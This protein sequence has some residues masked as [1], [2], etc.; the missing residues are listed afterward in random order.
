MPTVLHIDGFSTEPIDHFEVD[1][2]ETLGT[3][4]HRMG[5]SYRIEWVPDKPKI[6]RKLGPKAAEFIR[7]YEREEPDSVLAVYWRYHSLEA[8]EFDTVEEA[9]RFLENGAEYGSLAG[10]AVVD[11]DGKVTVLP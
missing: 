11:G 1:L 6:E 7:D 10:E 4:L 3:V 9:E 2:G 5:A 8:E